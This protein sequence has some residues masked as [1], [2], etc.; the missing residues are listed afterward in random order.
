MFL[1]LSLINKY[2]YKSVAS[3]LCTG[4]T[5]PFPPTPLHPRWRGMDGIVDLG[6]GSTIAATLTPGRD[7]PKLLALQ[8][9]SILGLRKASLV[10]VQLFSFHFHHH[11]HCHD[12]LLTTRT[13]M[14]LEK[15]KSVVSTWPSTCWPVEM[16]FRACSLN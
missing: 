14:P 13:G 2:I 15:N 4:E 8:L 16:G 5:L 1:S 11:H 6:A 10:P 12:Y 9:V 7:A 3:S